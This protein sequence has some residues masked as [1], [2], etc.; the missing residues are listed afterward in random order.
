MGCAP[1]I[2]QARVPA[3]Q[4]AEHSPMKP[5][6]YSVTEVLEL[7]GIS[8]SKFYQLVNGRQIKVRKIGN[9]TII[10]AGDLDDFLQRLPVLGESGVEE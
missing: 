9:R 5:V 6:A 3:V 7:I 4:P 2:A 1:D 10:L 8:R